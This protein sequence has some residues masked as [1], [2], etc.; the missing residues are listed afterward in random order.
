MSPETVKTICC[1][2]MGFLVFFLVCRQYDQI[3]MDL[4]IT[5]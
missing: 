2:D 5:D 4:L 3:E 1:R